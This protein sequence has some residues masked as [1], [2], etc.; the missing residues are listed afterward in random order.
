MIA[1][2]CVGT[3]L[4]AT[5]AGSTAPLQ[6]TGSVN[7][8]SHFFQGWSRDQTAAPKLFNRGILGALAG[9]A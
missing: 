5:P 2:H 8:L 3:R 4:P 9:C 7:N 6:C 1:R